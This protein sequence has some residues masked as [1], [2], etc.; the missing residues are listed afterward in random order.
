MPSPLQ[1][2]ADLPEQPKRIQRKLSQNQKILLRRCEYLLSTGRSLETERQLLNRI[3]NSEESIYDGDNEAIL[4]V[5]G[6]TMREAQAELGT[7]K[8]KARKVLSQGDGIFEILAAL[9]NA[10]TLVKD[11][12]EYCDEVAQLIQDYRLKP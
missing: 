7:V 3:Q 2:A 6:E 9:A 10:I 8:D 12:V 11:A 5:A 1:I 4:T